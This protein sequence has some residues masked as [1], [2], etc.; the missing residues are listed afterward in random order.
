ML[1]GLLLTLG[2]AVLSIGLRTFHNS[3]AQ[4]AGA[5]GILAATFLTFYFATNTWVW[6]LIAALAWLFLPWLEILTRIR[7]LR[8]PKEKQLRP[9][10]PPS[11][12]TFPALSEVTREIEDEAFVYVSDAGWDWEDYRQFFRLFYRQEDG[13][14]A[15][16]SPMERL[17]FS[18]F[19]S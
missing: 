1:F 12:D 7:A 3:Y 14:Q 18:F 10:S 9:K 13:A 15:A 5:L 4:K 16:T 2:V 6:G 17:D 11:S 19:H 8:L